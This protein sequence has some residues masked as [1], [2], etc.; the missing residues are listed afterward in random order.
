[1]RIDKILVLIGLCSV[2]SISLGFTANRSEWSWIPRL[3]PRVDARMEVSVKNQPSLGNENGTTEPATLREMRSPSD[4]A[5]TQ[6]ENFTI[7]LMGESRNEVRTTESFPTGRNEKP[8]NV[9]LLIVDAP[10]D[11]LAPVFHPP[12]EHLQT[13]FPSRIL[14]ESCPRESIVEARRPVCD[15]SSQLRT[16][17][18]SLLSWAQHQRAMST[19]V[20]YEMPAV[21]LSQSPFDTPAFASLQETASIAGD[22]AVASPDDELWRVADLLTRLRENFARG[23]LGGTRTSRLEHRASLRRSN[24]QKLAGRVFDELAAEPNERGCVVVASPDL[25]DLPGAFLDEVIEQPN[26]LV[27]VVGTCPHDGSSV[28]LYTRGPGSERLLDVARSVRLA[29]VPNV[30]RGILESSDWSTCTEGECSAGGTAALEPIFVYDEVPARVRS[31]RD[32]RME[33]GVEELVSSSTT[34]NDSPSTNASTGIKESLNNATT[35][36]ETESFTTAAVKS[37]EPSPST[38]ATTEVNMESSTNVTAKLEVGSIHRYIFTC[39]K[40]KL[41]K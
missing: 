41:L 16:N 35:A 15:C 32:Q 1:M 17:V 33:E 13:K 25:D 31:A 19:S 24:F 6:I 26:T 10:K 23:L 8:R 28:W 4:D 5:E 11:R 9:I 36:I 30:I 18:M 20:M 40:L 21:L 34:I 39:V 12:P 7:D 27:V 14:L 38:S 29:D 2:V 3:T 37:T 22:A